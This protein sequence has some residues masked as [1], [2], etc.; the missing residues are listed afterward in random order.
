MKTIEEQ[1][2]AQRWY[3]ALHADALTRRVDSVLRLADAEQAQMR[4]ALAF[5]DGIIEDLSA[6]IT[7]VEEMA[8]LD[9]DLAEMLGMTP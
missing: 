3:A 6:T 8:A 4:A 2:R 1:D 9:G 5:K 7:R